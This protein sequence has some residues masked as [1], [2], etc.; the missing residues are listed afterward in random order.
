MKQYAAAHE[1]FGHRNSLK[2]PFVNI[3]R[4]YLKAPSPQ[5][6]FQTHAIFKKKWLTNRKFFEIT[7]ELMLKIS[8]I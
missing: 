2:R 6:I 7:T 5:T 1:Q 4:H 3:K 8:R